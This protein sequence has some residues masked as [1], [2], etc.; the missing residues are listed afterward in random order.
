MSASRKDISDRKLT[1]S[2]SPRQSSDLK[3]LLYF[4]AFT[5]LIENLLVIIWA[6]A[7]NVQGHWPTVQGFKVYGVAMLCSAAASFAAGLI[8]FLFGIPRTNVQIR[9][10]SETVSMTDQS[11]PGAMDG[12]ADSITSR[13]TN[14][15]Q[16][17]VDKKGSLQTDDG[18]PISNL[19]PNTNLEEISDGLTKALLGIGLSQIYRAG[20]WV[21]EIAA[22]LGPSFGTGTTGKIVAL[23]VIAYGG[24][25]GFFFGYLLTR[26]FLTDA[27]RRAE[28]GQYER[29]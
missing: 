10:R 17:G 4:F 26:I 28:A 5:L 13:S 16:A 8:G 6:W 3:T 11:R 20:G 7:T 21:R 25:A 22:I 1:R 14:Q 23:S 27:F 29:V 12:G 9:V 24:F 18:N 15:P 2:L 19:R